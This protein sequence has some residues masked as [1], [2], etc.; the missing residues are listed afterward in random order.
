MGHD[1]EQQNLRHHVSGDVRFVGRG[2]GRDDRDPELERFVRAVDQALIDDPHL[3][4]ECLMVA[5]VEKLD[6]IYREH[7]SH[8]H[9]LEVRVQLSPDQ[10]SDSDLREAALQTFDQWRKADDSRFLEALREDPSHFVTEPG[11]I[12][13]ASQE[14]RIDTLLVDPEAFLW[15]RFDERAWNVEFHESR[16]EDSRDL[17]DTAMRACWRQG[18]RVR[19][20]DADERMDPPLLARIRY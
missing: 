12:V 20:M 7:S 5:A 1:V 11:A 6:A 16:R 2:A 10:T 8:G 9:L 17:L 14:G 3:R 19:I 15:G 13:Q 18:G 4:E